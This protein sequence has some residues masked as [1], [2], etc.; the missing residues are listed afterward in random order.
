M[1][2]HELDPEVRAAAERGDMVEAIKLLRHQTG[3]GLREAKDVIE[4]CLRGEDHPAGSSHEQIPLVAISALQEGRLIDA[5]RLT[6]A[7]NGIGLKDAKEAVD[8]YLATNSMLREQFQAAARGARSPL[9][10]L[11]ILA[12]LVAALFIGLRALLS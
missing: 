2:R 6:R 10:T 1:A 12:L 5:I 4:G 11:V 7:A 9:R 8:H 3:L